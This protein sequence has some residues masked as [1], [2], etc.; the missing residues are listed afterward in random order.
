MET[1]DARGT[2]PGDPPREAPDIFCPIGMSP[3]ITM[4]CLKDSCG[5]WSKENGKCSFTLGEEII[6]LLKAITRYK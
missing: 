1:I 5:I 3:E 6:T 2:K 4:Y